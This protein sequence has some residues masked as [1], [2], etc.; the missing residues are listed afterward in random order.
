[1]A[2]GNTAFFANEP[3]FNT[4][5]ARY[6]AANGSAFSGS[7]PVPVLGIEFVFGL[8]APPTVQLAQQPTEGNIALHFNNVSL[9]IYAYRDNQRGELKN[10]IP[11]Q[12]TVTGTL[13][14][15]G[16]NLSLTGLKASGNGKLDEKAA[17]MMNETMV[18]QFQAQT[19]NIPLPDFTKVVGQPVS[20]TGL[21][22]E[23]NRV[24]VFAQIG[25]SGD[26]PTLPTANP[27]F[28]AITASISGGVIN[29]LA[30][31]QFPGEHAR[32]GD[33]NSSMGFGYKANAWAEAKNPQVFINNGEG[34]GTLHVAAGASGGIQ[35]FGQ[36]LEHG[37]SVGTNTP[38]LN[39]RLVNTGTSIIVK[40]YLNG[41]ISF[42][43][44]LPDV[45]E[46]VA[47][48]ILSVIQ[49]LATVITNAVNS[50][51]NNI[52]INAFTLPTT[53]P[54]TDFPATLSFAEAGFQGNSVQ[55]VI[56]V[57]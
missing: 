57:G 14:L 36:W 27:D 13:G 16:Q 24:Q 34:L 3:L 35:A 53:I 28:P 10:T 45:L 7:K 19:A 22:V 49:P 15:N 26:S 48:S 51:L 6:V 12:V 37:I 29:Q 55:A 39:L 50:G 4:L 31:G 41:T 33:Q 2:V 32:A 52:T 5:V 20:L 21:A 42:N 56:R 8:E 9:A 30:G 46:K 54:G 23:N 17:A 25:S 40:V 43:F 1:M 11:V 18:P 38:P 47:G 44:G